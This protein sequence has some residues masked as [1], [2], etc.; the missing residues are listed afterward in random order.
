MKINKNIP[1]LIAVLFALGANTT[2]AQSLDAFLSLIEAEQPAVD[3][4]KYEYE[5]AMLRSKQ[6]GTLQDPQI[7]ANYALILGNQKPNAPYTV[8]SVSAMQGMPWPGTRQARKNASLESANAQQ[9]LISEAQ[10]QLKTKVKKSYYE[11]AELQSRKKHIQENEALLN[12]TRKIVVSRMENGEASLNDVIKLDIALQETQNQLHL[13]Q[14][15]V[16]SLMRSFNLLLNRKADESIEISDSL[17]PVQENHVAESANA[18]HPK[19]M[20]LKYRKQA[21]VEQQK[22]AHKSGFPNVSL[23]LGY[24][25]MVNPAT[26]MGMNMMMPMF[27][28]SLPLYRGRYK[29]AINEWKNIEQ[30]Y[31]QRE[32]QLNNEWQAAIEKNRFQMLKN[33]EL[34]K[35]NQKQSEQVQRS[36]R[37]QIQN[38]GSSSGSID[39]ILL[40]QQQLIGYQT[41]QLRALRDYHIAQ[42]EMEYLLSTTQP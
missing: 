14:L 4:A 2:Q 8:F 12:T 22:A 29:A 30:A 16:Q 26:D 15:E 18:V 7:S 3:A 19:L 34:I 23:G 11:L 1:V 33:S 41:E 37:L 20:E 35:H 31:E 5:A 42:A 40:L 17:P 38:Y 10:I 6:T 9:V 21:S 13:L 27:G 39:G 32:I 36:L 24:S 28:F 25:R